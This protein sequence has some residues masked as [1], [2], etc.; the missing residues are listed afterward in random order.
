MS[1]FEFT[2]RPDETLLFRRDDPYD[3]RWGEKVRTRPADYAASEVVLLGFPQDDGVRR[4]GGR[5]GAKAAPNAIRRCFYRTVAAEMPVLFDMGNTRIDEGMTLEDMHE[6]HHQLVRQILDD[7]KVL[8]VLGGGNDT[9]YPDCAALADSS[10]TPPLAFNIDAHFDVRADQPR[11]SGTPYR[12]LLEAGH[13][14]AEAFFEIAYQ[15]FANSPAYKAYLAEKGVRAFALDAVNETGISA[16]LLGLL[17]ESSAATV[18]WGLDMD[19]VRGSDAPGVSALNPTGLSGEAFC[20]AASVAGSERRTRLFE[21]TEVNPAY[22]IDERTCRLA[23]AAIWYFLEGR[24]R[25][26][27]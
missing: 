3:V 19:V 12:Q 4:N 11:N 6:R 26:Q 23:G 13:L 16:L 20:A 22:D 2:Q 14:R 8:I 9:S 24:A 21:I 25:V 10:G 5:V 27:K 18:F 17:R 1:V 7:S 15:P